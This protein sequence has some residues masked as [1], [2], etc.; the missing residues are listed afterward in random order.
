VVDRELCRHPAAEGLP[1][2]GGLL[3][4]DRV[5]EGQHLVDVV[6]DLK[7]VIGLVAVAVTDEVDRPAGEVLGVR[8]QVP[9]VGL[10][11]P[12]DAVQHHQRRLGWVPGVQ[13]AGPVRACLD[14]ALAELDLPQVGPHAGERARTDGRLGHEALLEVVVR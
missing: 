2:E 8:A 13:V 5:Q 12:G 14:E 6:L 3:D 1:G 11:V 9:D 10:G 7:G 4:A